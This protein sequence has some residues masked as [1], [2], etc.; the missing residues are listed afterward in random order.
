[1]YKFILLEICNGPKRY[2]ENKCNY[3]DGLAEWLKQ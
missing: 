1:M 3:I 2:K